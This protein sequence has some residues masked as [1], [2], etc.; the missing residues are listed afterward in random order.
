MQNDS[1]DRSSRPSISDDLTTRIQSL[2]NLLNSER[3]LSAE[4][5]VALEA[6]DQEEAHRL[7]AR[8]MERD[9]ASSLPRTYTD[10]AYWELQPG[11]STNSVARERRRP[12]RPGV[13]LDRQ[14]ERL[15]RLGRSEPLEQVDTPIARLSPLHTSRTRQASTDLDIEPMPTREGR[16]P[17]RR[18]LNDGT[19]NK[20]ESLPEYSLTAF[21]SPC[22]LKMTLLESDI[23]N[24]LRCGVADLN[25][26]NIHMIENKTVLRTRSKRCNIFMKHQGGWPFDL[27]RLLVRLPRHDYDSQIQGMVFVA[28]RDED[29]ISKT[30]F[31]DTLIPAHHTYHRAR[32]FVNRTRDWSQRPQSPYRSVIYPRL[33]HEP[34]DPQWCDVRKSDD[35]AE[36]QQNEGYRVTIESAPD[37]DEAG[38]LAS[39]RSPQAWYDM[40][41]EHSRRH[42][43]LRADS[44]R[45]TYDDEYPRSYYRATVTAEAHS[46][47]SP[48]PSD[49]DS[50]YEELLLGRMPSAQRELQEAEHRQQAVLDRLQSE[51]ERRFVR[52]ARPARWTENDDSPLHGDPTLSSHIPVFDQETGER[53]SRK[54]L[55][56]PSEMLQGRTA[57][58]DA[59]DGDTI[60]RVLPHAKFQVT[61]GSGGVT[62][63]FDPPV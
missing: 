30:E 14:R 60:K 19:A 57:Y 8:A 39:P 59:S 37:D 55:P 29:L 23:V 5:Q 3:H 61:R 6:L 12:P 28:L 31:Y 36:V 58:S 2:R 11:P 40:D 49:S 15:A 42:Y 38:S 17:K 20:I 44:Y 63:D 54:R 26:L 56:G 45:P 52:P 27:S 62:I 9:A 51:R 33:S 35:F 13:R 7:S 46:R 25:N 50:V 16:Y 48:T 1:Y 21:N 53:L 41:Q 43:A 24:D 34:G 18:K 22:N 4:Q 10:E 47:F 32:R